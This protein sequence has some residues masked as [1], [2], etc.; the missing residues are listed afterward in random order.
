MNVVDFSKRLVESPAADR[1]EL[2]RDIGSLPV[3][4]ISEL[5]Q[6]MCYEVWTSDPQR[7]GAIADSLDLLATRSGCR[8]VLGYS[9]WT[10][11]IRHL[12]NGDLS[13][14]V[15]QISLSEQVFIEIDKPLL[16]AQ[17][18]TSKLYALA[19]LGRYEEAI[20][21]GLAA[22]E[23]FLADNDRYSLGKIDHNIGNLFAR[24][25]M[26]RDAEKYFELSHECFLSI[27]DQ[28]Q[29]AMVENSLAYNKTLQ[30]NF[31]D[32]EELYERAL[33]RASACSL[34]VTEAEIETSLSNLRRFKGEFGL[35]VKSMERARQKYEELCMPG[36][37]AICSLEIAD[38]YLEINLLP[39]AIE[40]YKNA[41]VTF[42]GLEM[43]GELAR[44]SL[45]HAQACLRSG[46]AAEAAQLLGKAEE[47]Y[48]LEGNAVAVASVRLTN[49]QIS[50]RHG[51][52]FAAEENI[53]LA[54]PVF[55]EQSSPRLQLFAQ[56]LRSDIWR[57]L[58]RTED[59]T[60]ALQTTL[61]A[62]RGQSKMTE[63]L[64]RVSLGKLTGDATHFTK[65]VDLVEE[66][67]TGFVSEEIRS[68]FFADRVAPYDELVKL[69]LGNGHLEDAFRWH[70]RSRSRSLIESL[71]SQA[72]PI[73]EDERL[74]H[75]REDIN[76]I[77]N[78]IGRAA[79]QTSEGRKASEG[80]RK[81]ALDLEKEYAERLR[82]IRALAGT[83]G[84]ERFEIDLD[85]LRIRLGDATLIEFAAIDGRLTAFILT[86]D[87]FTALASYADEGEIVREI[88]NFLFQIMT[89]RI[90]ANLSEASRGNALERLKFQG[91]RLF[92]LL[93]GPLGTHLET[94]KII[95]V[96]AGILNYVPLQALYDGSRYLAQRADVS[97]APSSGVLL[98]CLMKPP[99]DRSKIVLAGIADR[100]TPLVETEID[101]IGDL[102][103]SP[104]KLIA[105]EASAKNLR[106]RTLDA[107]LLHLAC[108]GKFRSDNPG[109]SS[110]TLFEEE[111]TL[112]EIQTMRFKECII[113]LSSCESGLSEVLRGEELVGLTRAFFA[114]G[115][116]TLVTSLWRVNDRMTVGLM[117]NFYREMSQG[118][119]VSESL[120]RAQLTLIDDGVH[121]YFWAPFIVSGRW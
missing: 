70:E 67:R 26:Y 116:A 73:D 100:S 34:R 62:T 121:P 117:E 68:A 64:C 14:C 11:A 106:E 12:V 8:E 40:L 30:N 50:M 65:A 102:F 98:H 16:A 3:V 89:G 44:C 95:F 31:R 107:G 80:M 45:N 43:Q 94:Q 46:E 75:I 79:L 110:L 24:R 97:Y 112:N 111:L 23:V 120:R 38:L 58:G 7:I 57:A 63:Y 60:F 56:W 10:S 96:P 25:E 105:G 69:S 4:E 19:V 104:E 22:R 28:R 118:T 42:S 2:I 49:A 91:Q 76:W 35:A 83:G 53:E 52:L 15:E 66:S 41:G 103:T 72:S 55:V 61:A 51:D 84:S 6:K 74:R 47:L 33:Q 114:A 93:L 21:C 90:L 78:A 119:D 86:R 5:L 32:A 27:D 108:H 99:T 109:F 37:T 88:E 101:T 113:T 20:Q 85:E 36:Q 82:Q 71:Q 59:A 92:D 18:Q 87:N 13:A 77:H 9:I 48:L 54:L 39:E 81:Q 29:L 1:L 17:T 115:A